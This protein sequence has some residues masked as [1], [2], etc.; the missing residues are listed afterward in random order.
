MPL[1]SQCQMSTCAPCSGLQ[2]PEAYAETA[3]SSVSGSPGRGF[4]LAIPLVSERTSDRFSRSSTQYGP[5]VVV[6]SRTQSAVVPP[7]VTVVPPSEVP[8][9]SVPT[10]PS[11]P[12]A[13]RSAPPH[14]ERITAP[15]PAPQARL[16][17][18]PPRFHAFFHPPKPARRRW[19]ACWG[20]VS[21][22]VLRQAR[23]RVR[24]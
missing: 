22:C 17:K 15:S 6:G 10:P 1:A 13:T 16:E 8:L 18:A 9:L 20:H 19:R 2:T 12:E 24:P 4:G 21:Y 5:L 11:A 7:S 3:K 23:A 14:R